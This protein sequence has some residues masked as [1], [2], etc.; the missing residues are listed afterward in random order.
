M[1]WSR[2]L[3]Q[4]LLWAVSILAVAFIVN[5]TGI[6]MAGGIDAWRDWLGD[7]SGY[8]RAWRMALYTGLGYTTFRLIKGR[9]PREL[10]RTVIAAVAVLALLEFHSLKLL[11]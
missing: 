3:V 4:S 1:K 11:R 10:R 5:V 8:F 9:Q 7:S 6:E 2:P